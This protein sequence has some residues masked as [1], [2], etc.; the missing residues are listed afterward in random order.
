VLDS[1]QKI[2]FPPLDPKSRAILLSLTTTSGFGPDA[3]RFESTSIRNADEK[4]IAYHC[5]GFRL[6]DLYEGIENPTPRG[7][8]RSSWKLERRSGARYVMLATL[9]GVLVFI[10][11]GM[12]SLAVSAYQAWVVYQAWRHPVPN[13]PV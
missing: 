1:I 5:H 3:L 4:G 2:L 10:V 11:L 13:P 9:V 7:C 6:A 8:L 12:A